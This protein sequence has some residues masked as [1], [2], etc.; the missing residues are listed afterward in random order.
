MFGE[1]TVLSN[2]YSIV[3]YKPDVLAKVDLEQTEETWNNVYG[4]MAPEYDFTIGPRRE[5]MGRGQKKSYNLVDAEVSDDGRVMRQ[6]YI[7]TGEPKAGKLD[8]VIELIW[9]Q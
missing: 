4:D 1:D 7:F 2:G 8:E 6:L 9:T 5:A 3:A